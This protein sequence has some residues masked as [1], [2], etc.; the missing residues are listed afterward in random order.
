MKGTLVSIWLTTLT[1]LFGEDQKN[2]ILTAA[3][4]NPQRIITPLEEID[5]TQIK[6]IIDK[7]AKKQ[8]LKTEELYRILGKNNVQ[9]FRDWFPSYFE[10]NS[11][12]GFLMMMDTVH[13]QLTKM[14]AGAKPPRLIPEP[15]DEKNFVMV[16]KS[17]RGLHHYLMGLI[18]GVGQHFNEKIEAKIIEEG[19]EGEVHV[20]KIHLT[21]EKTP[22]KVKK[23]PFSRLLSFGFLRSIAL[24]AA[25]LPTLFSALIIL[26]LKGAD[27]MVLLAGIPMTVFVSSLLG[28]VLLLKPMKD[29]REEIESIKKLDLSQE[30][31]IITA[32]QFEKV[33]TDL[34]KA[35][36]HLKEE[37]TYYRGGMDDLYS[38]IGRFSKVSKNLGDVSELI[39]GSVEEVAEGAQ[40]QATETEASVN[41]LAENIKV[42]NEISS[43][44]LNEKKSLENAV[45]QIEVSFKDLEKVSEKMNLVKNN[46]S[47]VNE[48]GKDLG[49]KVKDII[50]IVG[51]VES[52]AE[53]T[54]LLALNA[55]IE[56][57]RAGEMGRGFSV[58]AEEIR[59]LAENSKDAVSTINTNLNEFILGVN[60]M[61]SEVNDQYVELDEGTKTMDNVTLESRNAAK[62]IHAVSS[63]I[64]DI[65]TKLSIETEQINQVFD[66]V[67]KLAAIAEENS[68]SSEEMSANV[69]SFAGEIAK[70]TENI[71]DL[72][73]VV[74]F[75]KNEL[76]RYKL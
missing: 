45:K 53:Q 67:H 69:T 21:F 65:S 1:R 11:A 58:V 19:K 66:N 60:E 52:I 71:G 48:T 30:M 56:A 39:A 16:Y 70:L 51:T 25:I 26:M 68:A 6:G 47:K 46:F 13:T 35:K 75:L 54:N 17:K 63:S 74:L 8:G 49:V 31:K 59:K 41:I 43:Q 76:N 44:E 34:T 20:V 72:E 28:S 2:E 4:W 42:L 24:K 18:E 62:R 23:Y 29:I 37:F 3:G 40:H 50:N 38:F 32:D 12:M 7:F 10:T 36:E 14:I 27:D 55:S 9:S 22:K 57:A 73:K 5:D 64:S 33:A 15:I 61:V